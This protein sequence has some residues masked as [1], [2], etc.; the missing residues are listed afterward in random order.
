MLLASKR[1]YNKGTGVRERI[2]H[3]PSP[4]SP[5]APCVSTGH[6]GWMVCVIS[7]APPLRKN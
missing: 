6:K 2:A 3:V 5:Y 7:S 4:S 1:L